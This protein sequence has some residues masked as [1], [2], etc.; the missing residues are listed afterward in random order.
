MNGRRLLADV[1]GTNV[2][3]G[4]ATKGGGLEN[5]R[6]YR[7][8]DFPSFGDALTDYLSDS[9][10]SRDI[11]ACA[12]GAAGPVDGD[13]V[14]ITNSAWSIDRAQISLRLGG[15]P[16]VLVNDLEA[17][18][19]AL[20]HLA[21]GE[22]GAMG[23]PACVRPEYRTMLAFN[24]GT[25]LGAASVVHRDGRWWTCPSEAGHMTLGA[26]NAVEIDMLPAETCI[27]SL[28]SGKGVLELYR[29][30]TGADRRP[31]ATTDG[32]S[33]VFARA[34]HDEA[35][36]RTLRLFTAV[37]GRIAGDLALAT[38]AW[39]GVYLCGSVALGWAA[40]AD[41]KQ[42]RAEFTRK[43]PMTARM[44]R[45]PTVVIRQENVSLR[46]LAMLPISV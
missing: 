26:T 44:Q 38:A 9:G 11:C 41:V 12:I 33:E 42:F 39:G 34:D 4:L 29:R 45:V 21:A 6:A 14:K 8:A 24:V 28:L 35:A 32:A 43:G 37:F 1:G 30:L 19:A 20:P 18:A 46:G 13:F 10:A 40:V 22:F 15:A 23:E 16:V 17:V 31:N 27:E 2:R 7:V 3:F 5:V 25:G 36:A